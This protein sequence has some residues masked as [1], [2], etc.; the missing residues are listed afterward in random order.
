[1]FTDNNDKNNSKV[2]KESIQSNNE[3]D[4]LRRVKKHFNNQ[5][6]FDRP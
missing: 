4:P 6:G 1:M 2:L 5:I 3:I